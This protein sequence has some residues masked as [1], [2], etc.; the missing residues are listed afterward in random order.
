MAT[1]SDTGFVEMRIGKVVVLGTEEE[2]FNCVVLDGVAG[3]RHLVIQ[4]GPTE[5]FSLAARLSGF[6]FGRPQTYQFAATLVRALGG[7][8]RQVRLDRIIE[9]AYAATVEVE[10]PLGVELVDARCSDALNM[11]A[12]MDS[13]I[14]VA[15]EVLDDADARRT[16]GSPLSDLLH[17]ALAAPPITVDRPTT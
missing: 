15:S 14:F 12:L 17:R 13:P 10:G 4:I 3:D 7:H 1:T 5:A 16:G 11:A 6:D 9:R 8:V 2:T